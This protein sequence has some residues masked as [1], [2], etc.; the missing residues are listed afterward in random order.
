MWSEQNTGKDFDAQL[1]PQGISPAESAPDDARR[2][3]PEELDEEDLAAR[4]EMEEM[5][6]SF[7]IANP[8]INSTMRKEDP[9]L[10]QGPDLDGLLS[11]PPLSES[12]S[13]NPDDESSRSRNSS[14]VYPLSLEPQ[15]EAPPL[16]FRKGHQSPPLPPRPSGELG[17]RPILSDE[18]EQPDEVDEAV[19][20]TPRVR[21]SS[22][23]SLRDSG[24]KPSVPPRRRVS[25]KVSQG[26]LSKS[27]DIPPV[28]AVVAEEAAAEEATEDEEKDPSTPIVSQ[29]PR[30]ETPTPERVASPTG[31]MPPYNVPSPARKRSSNSSLRSSR[32]VSVQ[33]R[34][35]EDTEAA[36]VET[37]GSPS[38]PSPSKATH[39]E[40]EPTGSARTSISGASASG[41]SATTFEDA[42]DEG[43]IEEES[44]KEADEDEA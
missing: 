37:G 18:V 30:D 12:S 26:E 3:P 40:I 17:R 35:I 24:P 33:V 36:H 31:H 19:M 9:L 13:P 14:L 7:G 16:P 1:I 41:A 42:E 23:S 43:D 6:L 15:D 5:M 34:K 11:T 22:G 28:D 25:P 10:L 38:S 29:F 20:T 21:E 39:E 2:L 8:S 4:R 32:R 27:E 44:V